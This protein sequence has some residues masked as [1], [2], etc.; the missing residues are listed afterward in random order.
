MREPLFG[1]YTEEE[2]EK[3]SK[4]KG[5]PGNRSTSVHHS[6]NDGAPRHGIILIH[7]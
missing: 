5:T 1:S 6:A 3:K 2:G 4:V 7:L